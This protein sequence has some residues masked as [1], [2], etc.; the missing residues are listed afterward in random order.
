MYC[1]ES[2]DEM[3]AS[4]IGIKEAEDEGVK[5]RCSVGPSKIL[6]EEGRVVAMEWI[7]VD[8][9]LDGSG[10]I[11]RLIPIKGSE[12]NLDLDTIILAIGEM[13][14]LS[15]LPKEITGRNTIITDPFTQET[16]IP[17]VYAGGDVVSGPATS[18]EAI[19]A[20][21]NAAI[22]ID[23]RLRKKYG[24]VRRYEQLIKRYVN[25]ITPEMMMDLLLK[26]RGRREDQGRSQ[27]NRER[28]SF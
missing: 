8:L 4:P 9:E 23:R 25:V 2:R 26:A 27:L 1:I 13:S 7:K 6:G 15:S 19:V 18:I 24:T 22:S 17:G 20:G 11:I 16:D 3:P 5:I 12:F 28:R 10:G 21:R 14:D